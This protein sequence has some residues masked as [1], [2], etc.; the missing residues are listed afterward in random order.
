MKTNQ[1][2]HAVAAMEDHRAATDALMALN[3]ALTAAGTACRA[4]VQDADGIGD[5]DLKKAARRLLRTVNRLKEGPNKAVWADLT[6]I[7]QGARAAF[8]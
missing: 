7:E 3:Q 2:H 1:T 6:L 5:A 8:K 4:L